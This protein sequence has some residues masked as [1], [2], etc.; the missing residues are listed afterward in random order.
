LTK[1]DSVLVDEARTPLIIAQ[2]GDTSEMETIY[3]QAIKHGP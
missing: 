3:T 1:A 2:K